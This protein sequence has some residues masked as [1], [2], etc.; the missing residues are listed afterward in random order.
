MYWYLETKGLLS[1]Y[2]L[3]SGYC[4][5]ASIDLSPSLPLRPKIMVA[6]F[7]AIAI[8]YLHLP[9]FLSEVLFVRVVDV[10]KH[11]YDYLLEHI[12]CCL[13]QKYCTFLFVHVFECS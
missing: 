2:H 9:Q 7:E 11:Q 12:E 13:T 1:K 10:L 5:P 8:V 6:I 4:L 3:A